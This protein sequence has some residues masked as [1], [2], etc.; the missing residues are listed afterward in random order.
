MTAFTNAATVACIN[1]VVLHAPGEVLPPEELRQR[2]CTEQHACGLSVV[3]KGLHQ[4]G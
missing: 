1:G 4:R 2:A 3:N